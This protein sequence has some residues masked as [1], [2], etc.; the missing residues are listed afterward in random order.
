MNKNRKAKVILLS[1]VL[2]FSLGNAQGAEL[3]PQGQ[4][5]GGAAGQFSRCVTRGDLV[6]SIDGISTQYPN[7]EK[8]DWIE[9]KDPASIDPKLV[10]LGH[11]H[12]EPSIA[13][14]HT[15]RVYRYATI[16]EHVLL[17]ADFYPPMP[18]GS[19]NWVVNKNTKTYEGH[20]LDENSR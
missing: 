4:A 7:I 20:F 11:A 10:E 3:P 16:G 12:M 13:V 9:V 2:M 8:L 15:L 6:V 17:C 14:K 18:D 5:Q 19:F 1:V